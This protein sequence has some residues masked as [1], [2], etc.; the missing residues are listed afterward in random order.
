M[1]KV[2]RIFNQNFL[3]EARLRSKELM[4]MDPERPYLQFLTYFLLFY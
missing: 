2:Q 1:K 4:G 3:D